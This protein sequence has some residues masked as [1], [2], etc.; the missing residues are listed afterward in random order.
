MTVTYAT[1]KALVLE[2]G[3]PSVALINEAITHQLG[4]VAGFAASMA[5][6]AG[7]LAAAKHHPWPLA[8]DQEG[9]VERRAA[10]FAHAQGRLTRLYYWRAIAENRITTAPVGSA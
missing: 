4:V 5:K 7:R 2:G 8:T 10:A 9:R 1:I 6:H 3:R